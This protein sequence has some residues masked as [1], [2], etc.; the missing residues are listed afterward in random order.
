[1]AYRLF[2][3][4]RGSTFCITGPLW[5]EP[6]VTGGFPSRRTS[7]GTFTH[8]RADA[9]GGIRVRFETAR[10]KPSLSSRNGRSAPRTRGS[11]AGMSKSS[12]LRSATAPRMCERSL[13]QNCHILFASEKNQ[14]LPMIWNYGAHVTCNENCYIANPQT[15]AC[16]YSAVPLWYGQF[17][18]K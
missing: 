15:M 7:K 8:T 18:P 3:A 17:S 2:G 10:S 13:M 12:R 9:G 11:G 4:K 6:P 16:M 5:G 14:E 1:M